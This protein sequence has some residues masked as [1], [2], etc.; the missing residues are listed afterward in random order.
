MRRERERGFSPVI[1]STLSKCSVLCALWQ[2][3]V[4][5]FGNSSLHD[6]FTNFFK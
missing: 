1:A 6:P 5:V 3:P 2:P 4:G